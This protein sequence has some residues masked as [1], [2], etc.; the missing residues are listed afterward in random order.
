MDYNTAP[1]WDDCPNTC[2][3]AKPKEKKQVQNKCVITVTNAYYR[4]AE[5]SG[6][7]IISAKTPPKLE[8]KYQRVEVDCCWFGHRL[9]TRGIK[10]LVSTLN[11]DAVINENYSGLVVANIEK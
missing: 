6:T 9:K 3:M 11:N 2:V 4:N 10:I 8:K 7:F 5:F 1:I